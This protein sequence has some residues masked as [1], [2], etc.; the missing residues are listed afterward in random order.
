[1]SCAAYSGEVYDSSDGGSTWEKTMLPVEASRYVH[2]YPLVC[3]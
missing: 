1:M 2:I 3:G